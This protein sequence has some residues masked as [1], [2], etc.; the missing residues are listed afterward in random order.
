[1]LRASGAEAP[2]ARWCGQ[3]DLFDELRARL[4]SW[5]PLRLAGLRHERG[6]VGVVSRAAPV[7]LT[8]REARMRRVIGIDVHRTFGEVV[9]WRNGVLRHGG[10]VDM[11]RTALEGF[12]KNLMATD[13][14]VIEATGNAVAVSRVLSPF[15]KRVIIANPLQVK[16]IAHAHVKTP[17]ENRQSRR[18]HTCE[19]AR[20]GLPAGDPDAGRRHRTDAPAVCAALPG[21]SASHAHQERGARDPLCA[22]DPEM[23]AC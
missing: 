16:A 9:I 5:P 6:S 20:C 8:E 12:A 15:V 14:V 13:E 21:R 23:L 7:P 19:P 18:R 1:M 22:P 17:C 3:A 11:T 2:G 10:R 4:S